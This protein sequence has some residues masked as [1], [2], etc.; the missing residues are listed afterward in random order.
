[1]NKRFILGNIIVLCTLCSI[2]GG[3]VSA[4]DNGNTSV[5][6]GEIVSGD[7][8]MTQPNDLSFNFKLNGENQTKKVGALTS[9][10]I[11]NRGIDEGWQITLKSSNFNTY[12]DNYVLKVAHQEI[13]NNA[14]VVVNQTE[15]SMKEKISLDT[16][17][18]IS[19]NATAG[20]YVANLEWNLQ[21]VSSKNINE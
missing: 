1:M 19:K 3:K 7:F 15:K 13:T 18:N 11:D 14:Q 12:K 17:V 20:T 2:G 4:E 10:I 5:I 21:P 6:S 8:S 9:A 16:Q